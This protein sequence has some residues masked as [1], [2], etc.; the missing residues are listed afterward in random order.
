MKSITIFTLGQ[1]QRPESS[2]VCPQSWFRGYILLCALH[3]MLEAWKW[4]INNEKI[5]KLVHDLGVL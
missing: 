1:T 5:N 3:S 4:V 2:H